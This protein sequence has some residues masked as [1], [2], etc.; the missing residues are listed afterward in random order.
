MIRQYKL[1]A[2]LGLILLGSLTATRAADGEV[3]TTA[4]SAA[5]NQE[6]PS[7][8]KARMATPTGGDHARAERVRTGAMAPG[9]RA[10]AGAAI[11][12]PDPQIHGMDADGA[13]DPAYQAAYRHCMRRKGF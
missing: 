3:A 8:T 2:T 11:E 12:S 4:D 1:A 7:T 6:A 13:R 5:C 9:S 10:L